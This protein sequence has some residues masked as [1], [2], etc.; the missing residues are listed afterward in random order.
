MGTEILLLILTAFVSAITGGGWAASRILERQHERIRN[1]H[2]ALEV[3]KA[4]IAALDH[5]IDQLPMEYVLKVDFIRE[6]ESMHDNFKLIHDKLDKL[7][8]MMFKRR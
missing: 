1:L 5:R 3:E 7:M 6:I 8:E 4:R 2:E